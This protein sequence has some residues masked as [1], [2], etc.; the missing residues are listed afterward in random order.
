MTNISRA[1]SLFIA[2][3][4]LCIVGCGSGGNEP[5]LVAADGVLTYKGAPLWEATVVFVPEKGPVA[6]GRTNLE[7]K[8][9]LSTGTRRG[10]IPGPC[11]VAIS[12]LS[13]E[14]ADSSD[15]DA[16]SKLAR[17]PEEAQAQFKKISEMQKKMATGPQKKPVSVIPEKYLK[18]ETSNLSYTIQANGD[19]HFKI[20]L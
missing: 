9:E 10:A 14:G 8:F 16:I 20:D 6:M 1:V 12:L 5:K 15:V 17:T 11:K 18:A 13:S 7:G 2:L 3:A 4:L 19:N